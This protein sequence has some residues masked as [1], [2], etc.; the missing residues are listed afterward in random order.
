MI[1]ISGYLGADPELR[2]TK[3]GVA[4]LKMRVGVSKRI[5]QADGT[6]TDG[7]TLWMDVSAWGTLAENGAESLAKGSRVIV[8]GDLEPRT[9]E[10]KDGTTGTAI[11]LKATDMGPSLVNQAARLSKANKSNKMERGMATLGASL[12]EV[13][14]DPWKLESKVDAQPEAAPF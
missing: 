2:F 9:F 11:E 7:E 6:W 4:F 14:G 13:M 10:K 3:N 12:G 1:T 5:K 8:T